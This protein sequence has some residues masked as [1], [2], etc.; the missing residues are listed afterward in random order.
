MLNRSKVVVCIMQLLLAACA[1]TPQQ[2][3][4]INT[5]NISM[6]SKSK[7][8]VSADKV[9]KIASAPQAVLSL[10]ERSKSQLNN[11]NFKG[12]SASLERAIRITP[13]YP[14][15]Y[16]YLAKVHYLE[17]KY[18]QARSLAKKT[19]SLGA[20]DNLLEKVLVLLDHIHE[21]EG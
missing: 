16:Y 6:P 18:S 3:Q 11:S 7:P 15:S 2:E 5:Q 19:L 12:A 17:G 21:S 14:D 13:R 10:I 9:N 8:V 4:V 1:S 20:Q